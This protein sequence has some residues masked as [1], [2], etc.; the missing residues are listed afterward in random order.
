MDENLKRTPLHQSHLALK[1]RMVPFG[2]WDMPV[3][4]TG[5]IQEHQAVRE[6]AGMFDVSHMGEFRFK[7]PDAL[8][9]LQG[10]TPNDVSKL[11]PGRAQYNML[12]SNQ[13]GLI[14]DIYIY[15]I[16]PDEYLMVVNASNIDKDFAHIQSL[17]KGDLEFSNESDQWGLIAVQGPKAEEILQPH[18]D[19]DL[20]KKKKNSVFFA[21]LLGFNVM[22]ART[23]YTGE[24][25]FE[26]FIKAEQA[27]QIW[28]KLLELGITPAGLGARDTLRLEAGFPLYGHEFN[29]TLTP[30]AT[31]YGWVIKDKDFYGKAAL[32]GQPTLRKLVGLTL[33]KVPARE[34]YPVKAAGEVVGMVTS[35]TLSPSLKKP[36]AMAYVD[37]A[38]LDQ[39]LTVEVRGKDAAAQVVELPFLSK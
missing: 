20:G 27:P 16:Q 26:V 35:G 21:Q 34:G 6:H 5:V 22:L 12:P 2:G 1:A 33:E 37:V 28:E 30:L 24:D 8:N 36:I 39:N 19:T 25:G 15:C 13:G 14:D 7:G 31:H 23:G 17:L 4:Y 3:Q 10:I 11:K 32:T 18:I 9:F 29:D 38:A